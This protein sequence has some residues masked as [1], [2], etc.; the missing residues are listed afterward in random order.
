MS[1]TT[2]DVIPVGTLVLDMMDPS[3]KQL[4]F[5]ATASGT[6]SDKPEKNAKKI[7]KAAE[8]MID[9]YPKKVKS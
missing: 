8:K 2:S 4:V 6:L 3:V 5:R 7:A 1:T 9:K